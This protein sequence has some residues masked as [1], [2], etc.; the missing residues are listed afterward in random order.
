MQK[1]NR[2][3]AVEMFAKSAILI[4]N[5]DVVP[6]ITAA[7]MLGEDAVNYAKWADHVT[8]GKWKG[9]HNAI[10]MNDHIKPMIEYLTLPGFLCAVTYSNAKLIEAELATE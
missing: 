1:M 7:A 2:A 9:Y 6:T 3:Q 8:S 10:G 5:D 4:G